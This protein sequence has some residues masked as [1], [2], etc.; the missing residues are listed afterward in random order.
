MINKSLM[1]KLDSLG[2]GADIDKLESYV[3]L[4]QDAAGMGNPIVT[5]IQ[6]DMYYNLLKELK[7]T[8]DILNRNWELDD[9]ELADIDE[10]LKSNKMYSIR[11]IKSKGEIVK[12]KEGLSKEDRD[13]SLFASIKLNGHAIRA[14]YKNGYLVGGSTRGRYKKGREILRHLKA[15]LPNYVDRWKD[16][17]VLEVRGEMLVK[18]DIFERELSDKLKTPLSAVTSL[19]RDSVTDDE[20]KYLDCVCYKVIVEDESRI[21][22]RSLEEQFKELENAGF[23]VPINKRYNGININNIDKIFDDILEDFSLIA[24]KGE[25]GYSSDG[26][27]V[28]VNDVDIMNRFGVDGNHLVGNF[29]IKMGRHWECSVYKGLI[30][31]VEFIPGK[32]YFTP[33]AIIKPV[34]TITGTQVSNVSLY[35]IGVMNSLGLVEGSEIYFRYGGETGVSLCLE[36]GTLVGDR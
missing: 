18:E 28:A 22:F 23:K 8:S 24:D 26:I 19:I 20:L 15:V 6:Y 16:E 12:F 3:G 27:V 31:R 11:T 13:I 29:A 17:R 33:K 36:D 30:E 4:L 1:D 10:L 21:K 5:D 34:R 14:V 25:I 35:N 7:P 2:F 9:N 32:K